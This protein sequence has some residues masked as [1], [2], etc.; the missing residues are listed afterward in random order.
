MNSKL[1]SAL[2][3]CR[4][5]GKLTAG[6]DAVAD[7]M[8][9]GTANLVLTSGD[10]SP[11]SLKEIRMIA[12]KYKVECMEADITMDEISFRIGRRSGILAVCDPG[13]ARAVKIAYGHDN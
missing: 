2:G 13:L 6:F 5:A 11:K 9:A 8:K 7:S 4:K 3:L 12:E 10:L 1:L